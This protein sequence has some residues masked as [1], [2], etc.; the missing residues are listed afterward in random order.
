MVVRTRLHVKSLLSSCLKAF[1]FQQFHYNLSPCGAFSRYTTWSLLS[2]LHIW[3]MSFFKCSDII[4][5]NILSVLVSISFTLGIPL[6]LLVCV[7][8]MAGLLGCVHSSSFFLS[9]DHISPINLPSR[10]LIHSFPLL[11]LSTFSEIFI[12]MVLFNFRICIWLLYL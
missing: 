12:S 11:L 10:S 2:F 1:I 9:S 6:L 4:S 7:W 8:H 5:P 3:F